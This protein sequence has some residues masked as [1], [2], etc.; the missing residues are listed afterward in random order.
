MVLFRLES[1]LDGNLS[2]PVKREAVSGKSVQFELGN[3]GS[4]VVRLT[5]R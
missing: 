1:S 3:L 2:V 4:G 5:K